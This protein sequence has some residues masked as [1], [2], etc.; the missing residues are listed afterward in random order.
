[1]SNIKSQLY[2]VGCLTDSEGKP[3]PSIDEQFLV[4]I[5]NKRIEVHKLPISFS[6]GAKLCV[7]ALTDRPGSVVALLIDCLT[8]FEGQTVTSKQLADLYPVGF[9]DEPTMIRYIDEYLKPKK[10]KWAEIY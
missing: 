9:Y 8:N 1:M 3:S 5:L 6:D 7:L 10:V 4:Q 2:L